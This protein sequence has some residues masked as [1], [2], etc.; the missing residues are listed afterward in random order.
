MKKRI[1]GSTNIKISEIGLGCASYWGKKN[2]SETQAIKVV[3]TA[4]D[5]GIN[6]LDTGHS[7]SDGN[8]ERSTRSA[9]TPLMMKS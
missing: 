2:F 4:L 1:L 6:F 7:Y 3:H 8:K 9:L 5:K